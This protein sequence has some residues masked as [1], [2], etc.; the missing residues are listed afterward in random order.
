VKEGRGDLKYCLS[1]AEQSLTKD[2]KRLEALLTTVRSR[3]N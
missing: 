2:I 1:C 3:M